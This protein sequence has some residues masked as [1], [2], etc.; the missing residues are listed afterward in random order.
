MEKKKI[1]LEKLDKVLGGEDPEMFGAE[2]ELYLSPRE[3]K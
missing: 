2:E 3:K 1:Y